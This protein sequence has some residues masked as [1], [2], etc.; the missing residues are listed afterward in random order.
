MLYILSTVFIHCQILLHR[1]ELIHVSCPTNHCCPGCAYIPT[2]PIY[3]KIETYIFDFAYRIPN[4]VESTTIITITVQMFEIP[5]GDVNNR[6][7]IIS[8]S[9]QSA[10]TAFPNHSS[11]QHFEYEFSRIYK[12]IL[13]L[14]QQN[15][16]RIAHSP[17]HSAIIN[18]C[19]NYAGCKWCAEDMHIYG[20]VVR[21]NQFNLVFCSPTRRLYTHLYT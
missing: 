20:N 2:E 1:I 18:V 7:R 8:L 3:N 12:R 21:V 13:G 19:I 10:F 14:W 15:T 5:T 9:I 4:I 11:R 6:L 17:T 16:T